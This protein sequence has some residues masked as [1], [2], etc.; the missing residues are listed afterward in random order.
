MCLFI[1]IER[2]KKKKKKKK[3]GRDELACVDIKLFVG[4]LKFD[5]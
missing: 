2:K 4:N 3:K 5:L 1:L